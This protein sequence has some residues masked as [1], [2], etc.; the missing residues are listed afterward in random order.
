MISQLSKKIEL[1]FWDWMIP[2]LSNSTR[3]QEVF[4]KVGEWVQKDTMVKHAA[5]LVVIACAG[6]AFGFLIF[7][8][9]TILL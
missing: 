2:Q 8:L 3:L 7:S 4:R 5:T 6:F 9:S 1:K